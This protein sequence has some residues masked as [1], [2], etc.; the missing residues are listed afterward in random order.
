[1]PEKKTSTVNLNIVFAFSIFVVTGQTRL[2]VMLGKH[3]I[4]L[5]N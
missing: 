2:S 5:G 3:G 4:R 1:M